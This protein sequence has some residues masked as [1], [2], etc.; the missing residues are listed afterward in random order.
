MFDN[1]RIGYIDYKQFARDFNSTTSTYAKVEN[2]I[3]SFNYFARLGLFRSYYE[4]NLNNISSDDYAINII[5]NS[6]KSVDPSLMIGLGY[7][8]NI[9]KGFIGLNLTYIPSKKI[10]YDYSWVKKKYYID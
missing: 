1:L 2:S 3:L 5:G 8:Q 7:H 10:T 4:V 9:S 6:S